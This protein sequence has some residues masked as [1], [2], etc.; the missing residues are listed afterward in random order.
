[1]KESYKKKFTELI[2][3]IENYQAGKG[4]VI[5][6]IICEFQPLRVGAKEIGY[7]CVSDK[8]AFQKNITPKA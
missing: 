5:D 4:G 2:A 1:M 6:E 3:A 7:F 8:R